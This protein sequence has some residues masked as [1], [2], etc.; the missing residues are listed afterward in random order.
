MKIIFAS[1]NSNKLAEIQQALG[2]Q[3]ELV[4]LKDIG[5][6]GEIPETGRTLEA[7]AMEKANYIFDRYG[8]PVFADD[9]GLEIDALNGEPGVDTAHYSGSRDALANMQKV[10]NGLGD[11]KNREAKFRTVIAF[12][13][14]TEKSLFQG[15]VRGNVSMEIAGEKGFGYD[16]IFIPENQTRTFAEMTKDE[17]STQSHRIR[18]LAKFISYLKEKY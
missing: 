17:K 10:L 11:S 12:V 14:G 2:N 15:E 7:N 4:S 18:A 6:T 8:E 5:F 3:F 13:N 1:N 9:S 16:P